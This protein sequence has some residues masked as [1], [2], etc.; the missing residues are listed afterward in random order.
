MLDSE[1]LK[2]L[3]NATVADR[4]AIIEII[5]RSLKTDI[6]NFPQPDFAA[7]RQ[8]SAFGFMKNTGRILGDIVTPTLP[9]TAW[10]VL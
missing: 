6:G 3:Q 9:E 7:Q 8:R 1:T 4:I 10:D 2:K 5:L